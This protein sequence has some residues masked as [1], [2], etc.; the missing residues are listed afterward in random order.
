MQGNVFF[1]LNQ[2]IFIPILM[3]HARLIGN[4]LLI[5]NQSISISILMSH[6]RLI[7]HHL[8][9]VKS[10]YLH[11]SF[12]KIIQKSTKRF[13]IVITS[14]LVLKKMLNNYP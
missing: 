5:L 11:R 7:V 9:D 8:D 4:V 3:S 14:T 12:R 1:V 10:F 2:S 6:A 13:S